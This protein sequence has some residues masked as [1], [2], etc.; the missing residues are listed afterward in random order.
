MDL[1]KLKTVLE[2]FENSNLTELEFSDGEE[3]LRLSRAR[4]GAVITES[5]EVPLPSTP[6]L[7]PPL[8]AEVAEISGTLVKSPMVG[9]FYQ[10]AGPDKPSFVEVGQTV[11]EGDTLCIVE[12]MKLMNEIPSP[13]SGVVKQI[14]A[15]NGAPVGYG[16]DLFVIE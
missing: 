4:S 2:L 12:A 13:V 1:R 5:P 8:P 16:D 11:R 7:A 9:T 10:A 3:K 15:E 6:P 14:L